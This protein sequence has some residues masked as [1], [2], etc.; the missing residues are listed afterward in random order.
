MNL[1]KILQGLDGIKAKGEL[2]IEV[3][4]IANDSRKCKE[5]SMFL[6]T[7]LK[8]FKMEQK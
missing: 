1:K 2:D 6:A 3:S 8:Q 7:Y 5:G 4:S